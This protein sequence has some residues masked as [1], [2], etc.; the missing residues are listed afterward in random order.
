M[1]HKSIAAG[2]SSFDLIEFKKIDGPPG[3]PLAMR[4]LPMETEAC[5]LPYAFEPLSTHDVG[6]YLYLAMFGSGFDR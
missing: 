4:L 1:H 5:R 2:R 3:P 6:S